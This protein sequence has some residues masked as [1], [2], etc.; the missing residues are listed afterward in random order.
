MS[1]SA[2]AGIVRGGASA[3]A[4]LLIF[5]CGGLKC[6]LSHNSAFKA[7]KLGYLMDGDEPATG[8]WNYDSENREPPPDDD[9]GWPSPPRSRLDDLDR[10]VLTELPPDLRLHGLGGLRPVDLHHQL[11]PLEQLHDRSGALVIVWRQFHAE[12][13]VWDQVGGTGR[14]VNQQRHGHPDNQPVTV[15]IARWRPDHDDADGHGQR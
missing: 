10:E 5:Y 8:R 12:G 3:R 4:G 9:P 7:E 6:M 15:Q 2:P 14:L 11:L 13:A 1:P